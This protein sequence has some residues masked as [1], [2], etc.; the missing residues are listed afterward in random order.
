M[1]VMHTIKYQQIKR[2]Q[3]ATQGIAEEFRA[4]GI[5][6]ARDLDFFVSEL[7][8][9]EAFYG[10]RRHMQELAVQRRGSA[11]AACDALNDVIIAREGY[12][13]E[14]RR[15]PSRQIR[16][17][18]DLMAFA[19]KQTTCEIIALLDGRVADPQRGPP[20]LVAQWSGSVAAGLACDTDEEG[21]PNLSVKIGGMWRRVHG[22][23][24]EGL[25]C[26]AEDPVAFAVAARKA[27][28]LE[29][30]ESPPPDR[31][32]CL[33][34]L[35]ANPTRRRFEALLEEV[36]DGEG[37]RV[38]TYLPALRRAARRLSEGR[39][40]TAWRKQVAAGADMIK[41][42]AQGA[43]QFLKPRIATSGPPRDP[44]QDAYVTRLC[45]I[46]E[47]LTGDK[48]SYSTCW[49]SSRDQN[50]GQRFGPALIFLQLGL[51][52]IDPGASEHQARECIDWH[53][54]RER[55]ENSRRELRA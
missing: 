5:K 19:R 48:V 3:A 7:P 47:G 37:S 12:D 43:L 10:L 28:D 31:L 50:D 54:S 36:A 8:D 21:K 16:L 11:T 9:E 18:R 42:V 27:L 33:R 6:P 32:R 44:A 40:T 2:H 22:D 24:E 29:K 14:A 38:E 51:R 41:A 55:K 45:K 30:K 49:P 39:L 52:L 17:A 20:V 13:L 53:R 4:H 34:D 23:M 26:L 1:S 25:R 15:L 35:I 46:Y